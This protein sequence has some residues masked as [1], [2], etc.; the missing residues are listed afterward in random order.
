MVTGSSVTHR[1]MVQGDSRLQISSNL[2]QPSRDSR[3]AVQTKED[4]YFNQYK[5][6]IQMQINFFDNLTNQLKNI[7]SENS[8]ERMQ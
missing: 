3:T 4:K 5:S 7:V 8:P 1:G 2:V 6:N